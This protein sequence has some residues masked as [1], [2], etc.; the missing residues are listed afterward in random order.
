MS[1]LY[2]LTSEGESVGSRWKEEHQ[3]SFDA[4]KNCLLSTPVLAPPRFN[5]PFTVDTDASKMALGACLLQENES[6]FLLHPIAYS[7]RKL[8]K[9]EQK[10]AAVELEALAIV[11]AIREY[12]PYIEGA[13]HTTIRTDSSALCSLLKRKDLLG[14]LAK[15]QIIL[16]SYNLN[17]I[18]R[19]GKT[20]TFCDYLSRFP[21]ENEIEHISNFIEKVND[22]EKLYEKIDITLDLIRDE[23]RKVKYYHDLYLALQNNIFPI[24][25]SRRKE[26]EKRIKNFELMMEFY[27]M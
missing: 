11:F 23:Q 20:N 1:P 10:Y 27:I 22:D 2:N 7:S 6:D 9:A 3:R 8:N 4:I 15:Y 18:H 19:P 12:R 21:K 25:R 14:R 24:K 5:K 17:I 26:I 13:E 16:Q